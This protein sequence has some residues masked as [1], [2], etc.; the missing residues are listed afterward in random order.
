MVRVG[1]KV[2]FTSQFKRNR[3]NTSEPISRTHYVMRHSGTETVE[4]V[5]IQTRPNG[6][7]FLYQV[8][9]FNCGRVNTHGKP[10]P[11]TF[12]IAPWEIES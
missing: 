7:V 6:E 9:P 10:K 3:F 5:D 8:K 1:E 12:W 11:C 2:T 4:V